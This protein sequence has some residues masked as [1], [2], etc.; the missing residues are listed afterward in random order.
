MYEISGRV[1]HTNSRNNSGGRRMVLAGCRDRG[2][3]GTTVH[4]A[5]AGSKIVN[6]FSR[7]GIRS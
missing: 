2:T 1:C 6:W 5:N 3:F 7:T 4:Q